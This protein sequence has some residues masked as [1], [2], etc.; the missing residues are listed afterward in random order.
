[1][2]YAKLALISEGKTKR[3]WATDSDA[4]AIAEFSD[5]AMMYHAKKK[6]YFK[7]MYNLLSFLLPR[8]NDTL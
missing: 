2:S 5:D 3:L 4:H 8:R 7:N 1:M 6:L